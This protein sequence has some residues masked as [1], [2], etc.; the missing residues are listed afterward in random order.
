MFGFKHLDEKFTKL[1]WGL[2]VRKKYGFTS[3][4]LNTHY[5]SWEW[6]KWKLPDMQ[7]FLNLCGL[8]PKQ[9]HKGVEYF[10]K[11]LAEIDSTDRKTT[12]QPL[13]VRKRYNK[14]TDDWLLQMCKNNIGSPYTQKPIT[15]MMV[16]DNNTAEQTTDHQLGNKT[17]TRNI[18]TYGS[19]A[20][21]STASP[22][23]ERY[24]CPFPDSAFGASPPYTIKEGGIATGPSPPTDILGTRVTFGT[25]TINAAEIVTGLVTVGHQNGS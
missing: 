16:G 17:L 8:E 1:L 5:Y 7:D 15:D 24:V 18:A 25:I 23:I 10:D 2:A 4:H 6:H 20:A 9:N 11:L 22:V 19:K 13:T 14:L 21:I 3:D 12:I